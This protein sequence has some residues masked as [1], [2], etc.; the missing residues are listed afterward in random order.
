MQNAFLFPFE[1]L[2]IDMAC[3][4]IKAGDSTSWLRSVYDQHVSFPEL[5][6]LHWEVDA[7]GNN[8]CNFPFEYPIF[9]L[10]GH[11]IDLGEH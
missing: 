10:V 7:W 6:W 5:F 11:I 9:L 1:L 3:L 8:F 4:H 2:E